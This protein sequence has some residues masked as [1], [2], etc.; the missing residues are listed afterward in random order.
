MFALLLISLFFYQNHIYLALTVL[1]L[2]YILVLPVFYSTM[3]KLKV[4]DIFLFSLFWEFV[5][6]WF[7][8]YL[9]IR[10]RF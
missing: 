10:N 7:Y 4:A 3:K 6:K 2:R 1:I 8:V 5:N 9:Y